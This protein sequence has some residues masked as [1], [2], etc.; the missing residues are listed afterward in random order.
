ML[1]YNK[2]SKLDSLS[3]LSIVC[4]KELKKFSYCYWCKTTYSPMW[5]NGP[6]G[7]KTLCNRCGIEYYRKSKI[8]KK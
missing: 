7:H 8:F 2:Y 5:R 3:I 4:Q 1:H 6:R